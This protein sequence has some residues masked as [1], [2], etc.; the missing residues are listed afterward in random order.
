MVKNKVVFRRGVGGEEE[1]GF[2]RWVG[3]EE[4]QD[5]ERGWNCGVGGKS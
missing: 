1:I 4:G 2:R 5:D 3:R